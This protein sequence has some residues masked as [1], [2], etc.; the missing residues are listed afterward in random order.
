MMNGGMSLISVEYFCGWI[1]NIIQASCDLSETLTAMLE[2]AIS[3][4]FYVNIDLDHH[5]MLMA[6]CIGISICG[7]SNVARI[8]STVTLL[9]LRV[10]INYSPIIDSAPYLRQ[11]LDSLRSSSLFLDFCLLTC[12]LCGFLRAFERLYGPR[13]IPDLKWSYASTKCLSSLAVRKVRQLVEFI[14]FTIVPGF[15]FHTYIYGEDVS[16]ISKELSDS[17]GNLPALVSKLQLDPKIWE[18]LRG[19]AFTI[20]CCGLFQRAFGTNPSYK[21]TIYDQYGDQIEAKLSD[22]D[23]K[24]IMMHDS[25]VEVNNKIE[26]KPVLKKKS[27]S[28]RRSTRSPTEIYSAIGHVPA[29]DN[30]TSRRSKDCLRSVVTE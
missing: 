20:I 23:F 1:S 18:F 7:I 19:Y 26:S 25:D 6:I 12:F 16:V 3:K 28:K 15:Y 2:L 24:A 13:Q 5:I 27:S 9:S 4:I 8:M 11:F 17:C 14:L 29:A 21:S 10:A 22:D 30:Q